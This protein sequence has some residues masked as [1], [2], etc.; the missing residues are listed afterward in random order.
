MD[1][2][3]ILQ[4]DGGI[5]AGLLIFLSITSLIPFLTGPLSNVVALLMTAGAMFPFAISAVW[6]LSKYIKG[7]Y[8]WSEGII[9]FVR[10]RSGL[11]RNTILGDNYSSI[12]GSGYQINQIEMVIG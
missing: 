7:K 10:K 6:L 8:W 5:I 11:A 12:D 3:A 9:A 4:V 2:V 1:D